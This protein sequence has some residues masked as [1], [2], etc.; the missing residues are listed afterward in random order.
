M[1]LGQIVALEMLNKYAK[2]HEIG[3]NNVQ[4]MINL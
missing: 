4:A 3:F 1:S 2:F